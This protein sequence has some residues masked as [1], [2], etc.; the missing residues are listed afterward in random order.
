MVNIIS[1]QNLFFKNPQSVKIADKV[2]EDVSSHCQTE[3]ID[4]DGIRKS[5]NYLSGSDAKYIAYVADNKIVRTEENYYKPKTMKLGNRVYNNI[6]LKVSIPGRYDVYSIYE[7][8]GFGNQ[9][10][11]RKNGSVLDVKE[12]Q[13]K[14]F[15]RKLKQPFMKLLKNIA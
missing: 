15:Y 14:A 4:N 11:V 12:I 1:S 13:R 5:I 2:Y 3:F 7:K 6:N 8:N 9:V 10:R